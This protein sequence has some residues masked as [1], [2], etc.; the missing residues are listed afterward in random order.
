MDNTEVLPTYNRDMTFRCT[1]RDNDPIAGGT[2][3]DEV[4]FKTSENAGPFRVTYPSAFGLEFEVVEYVEVIWNVANTDGGLVDCQ[5]V[6]ISLS[7]PPICYWI[8]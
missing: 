1:V 4:R 8:L 5:L 7:I 2:V 3:W 6:D